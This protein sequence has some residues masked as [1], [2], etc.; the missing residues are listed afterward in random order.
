MNKLPCINCITLTICKLQY[1]EI[2]SREEYRI[3]AHYDARIMLESKCKLIRFFVRE[4]KRTQTT[5]NNR[6]LKL[7]KFMDPDYDP[8]KFAL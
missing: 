1:Q 2:A 7:T 5:L 6:I 8:R 3:I 4:P